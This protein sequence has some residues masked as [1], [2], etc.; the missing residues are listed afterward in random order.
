M[1]DLAFTGERF[2][3]GCAGEIAYEHW[4]RYAFA[5]RFVAGKRVLD[6]ACGEGYGT[7]LLGAQ[8][9]SAVGVDIDAPTIAHASAR[10]GQGTRIRFV[11]GSCARLPLPDASIDV[12][13]S[14]ETVEHVTAAD[15]PRMIA[16]FARVLAPGGIVVISSPNKRLYSDA[17][18]Y[19]NEF[20]LHELYREDFARLLSGVFPALRWHHQRVATWSGIWAEQPGAQAGLAEAWLGSAGDVVPYQIDDGMYFVV[21][22]AR[23]ASALP[24]SPDMSLLADAEDSEG[25][26][27]LHNEREMLRL[28]ALLK[29][30]NAGLDRQAAQIQQLDRQV[31]E[32]D[33]AVGERD[34][35]LADRARAYEQSL[36]EIAERERVIAVLETEIAR[37]HT[38]IKSREQD[39]RD[40]Q[41]LRWWALLPWRRLRSWRGRHR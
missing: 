6:A 14:F 8:A 19:V 12:I 34:R 41:S 26:R 21:I 25:A 28:D 15:Q 24:P 16:E 40:R 5:R 18:E 37:L 1:S 31:A 33:A 9:A 27:A 30:A 13:V 39:I 7:A 36:R 4:H 20:H 11:E 32:R 23:D 29:E 17:R 3:P 38:E 22:A 10:Y 35:L 2:L